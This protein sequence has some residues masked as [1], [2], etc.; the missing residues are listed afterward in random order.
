MSLTGKLKIV[1]M[2]D[3]SGIPSCHRNGPGMMKDTYLGHIVFRDGQWYSKLKD[4][5]AERGPHR[6]MLAAKRDVEIAVGGEPV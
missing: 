1:W 3:S 2:S 4:E 6:S 5:E